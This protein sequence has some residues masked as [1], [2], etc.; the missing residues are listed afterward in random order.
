[1]PRTDTGLRFAGRSVGVEQEGYAKDIVR[2]KRSTDLRV[3][4]QVTA[5]HGP[6]VHG[7][8]R[9]FR[10]MVIVHRHAYA[11]VQEVQETNRQ[12][13]V[14]RHCEGVIE[15]RIAVP[16]H[17]VSATAGKCPSVGSERTTGTDNH[18]PLSEGM[19][20]NLAKAFRTAGHNTGMG[21]R[22]S[23]GKKR[24]TD[25]LVDKFHETISLLD[26]L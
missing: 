18:V 15:E 19:R 14:A 20:V 26:C 17:F 6:H 9:C 8:S 24:R 7:T 4:V 3:D 1:M 25:N 16:V 10:R 23:R 12:E 5:T 11:E 21:K 13:E 2:V 22:K